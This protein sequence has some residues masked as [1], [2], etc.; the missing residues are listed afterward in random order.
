MLLC[1]SHGQAD[2]ERGYSINQHIVVEN[3]LEK[4]LIAFRSVYDGLSQLP[5]PYYE[6][7]LDAELKRNVSLARIRYARYLDEKKLNKVEN[8]Q[9]KK[10][11]IEANEL[12]TLVQS[13]EDMLKSIKQ[14]ENQADTMAK[15]A[16]KKSDFT[17]LSASNALGRRLR[18][19]CWI[20]IKLEK[21][22]SLTKRLKKIKQMFQ[23]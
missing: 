15:N 5:R 10:R 1:I 9:E 7:D 14:L 23:F 22:L 19:K 18:K 6:I 8:E 17:L 21:T 11:K 20:Y 12:K 13:E 16:E 2:V 3:L 4:S